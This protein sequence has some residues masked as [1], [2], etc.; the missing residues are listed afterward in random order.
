VSVYEPTSYAADG[1]VRRLLA[2]GMVESIDPTPGYS[3]SR[4]DFAHWAGNRRQLR[5]EDFYR[6]QRQRLD[7]L[8]EGDRPV[9]GRWSFDEED[10]LASHVEVRPELVGEQPASRHR[11]IMAETGDI[12]APPCAWVGAAGQP[13]VSWR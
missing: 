4:T 7:L 12:A 13:W 11:L 6:F 8:V 1:L 2:S 9:G 5:M 10:A 3:L